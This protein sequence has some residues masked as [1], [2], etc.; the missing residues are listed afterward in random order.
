MEVDLD[1][2]LDY[3]EE[4]HCIELSFEI[5][6]KNTV[7]GKG[8]NVYFF[9]DESIPLTSW[10]TTTTT[11]LNENKIR[12]LSNTIVKKYERMINKRCVTS[13]VYEIIE[14]SCSH[15]RNKRNNN[16]TTLVNEHFK[17]NITLFS[18]VITH[19]N[20]DNYFNTNENV[21]I[22]KMLN[23]L[24]HCLERFKRKLLF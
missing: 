2:I 8:R 10:S 5:K 11:T 9:I 24:Y 12:K 19:V 20:F 7:F 6:S 22:L 18:N 3:N 21:Q 4:Y 23:R 15:Y 17:K 16:S 13:I 1:C 14:E